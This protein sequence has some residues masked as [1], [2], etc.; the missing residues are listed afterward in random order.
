MTGSNWWKEAVVYQIYP[1]SFYDSNGDGI[2]D[3][4]GVI[5]K[6]DYLAGLGIDV[7][8]LC[9]VYKSPNDDNGYDISDYE[10]IMEDFGTMD[11]FDQLLDE[12]HKR[13][14]KIIMDLV[15]NHTSD[16]HPWFI[17][18]KSSLNNPKRDWYIWADGKNG[19]E[20]NNWESIFSGSAWEWDNQTKQYYMHLFSTKQ[21]DLNWENADVRQALYDMVNRWIDKGIDGFRIDAISHIKKKPGFPDMPSEGNKPYV[22]CFPYMSNY[23]GI[24][25]HLREFV[26]STIKGKD[27]MTVG[28]ANG[29]SLKDIHKW[30]GEEDGYFNMIFQFEH[31]RLWNKYENGYVDVQQ[32]MKIL[33]DWQYT[34]ENDGWNALF[35]ENHDLT[36]SVSTL[37]DDTLYREESAKMLG[38]LYFF[39]KGTPFIYQGQEIGMTNAYYMNIEDYNDVGMLKFYAIE[40]EKGVPHDELIEILKRTCRDNGRSPMQWNDAPFGGFTSGDRTWLGVNPNY[41]EINVAEQETNEDSVLSFYKKMIALRKQEKVFVYGK[42]EYLNNNHPNI[43]AYTRT[44]EQTKALILC[45]FG[46]EALKHTVPIEN[47]E[48]ILHNYKE[49]NDEHMLQ[50][51]EVRVYLI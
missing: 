27:L 45:N 11:D 4:Q 1:R 35:F 33:S 12:A 29:V 3:L 21:P 39:M 46:K 47:G 9:P 37:G 41:K 50:P 7:I 25:E 26:D 42:Y 36:R 24:D 23:E 40:R 10:D 14:I 31:L 43:V 6:L 20:P 16:E 32:L 49:V 22:E 18:S 30:V 48:L 19:A 28:E 34:L 8:W 5:Q 51:Y 44:M 2:G 17:E 15:L 13:G 38:A